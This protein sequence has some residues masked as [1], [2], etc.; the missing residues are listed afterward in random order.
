MEF[1]AV[2]YFGLVL[3]AGHELEVAFLVREFKF[4]CAVIL[5]IFD[6]V[7]VGQILVG[8]FMPEQDGFLELDGHFE[9]FAAFFDL[10]EEELVFDV[11]GGMVRAK[12]D[13]TA[14]V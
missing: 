11:G 2:G 8:E 5:F 12:V 1:D 9:I 14:W 10:N 13:L 6:D 3:E 4:D 7:G